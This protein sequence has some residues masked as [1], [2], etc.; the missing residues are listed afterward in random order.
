MGYSIIT[1]DKNSGVASARNI[2]LRAAQG[3]Y[4]CF[5]DADDI[6]AP[7]ALSIALEAALQCGS[8]IVG[9][10]WNLCFGKN[11]RHMVQKD[12]NSSGE[13]L[14]N[15]FCGVM[16]WNLWLYLFRRRLIVDNHLSFLEGENMGEDMQFVLKAF[17][18]SSKVTQIHQMLYNYNAVNSASI[19]KQ[20]SESRRKEINA[21]V[22]EVC[23]FFFDKIENV[24][25][26]E[27]LKLNIKQP[28][29][30]SGKKSDYLLWKEWMPEANSFA[31]K[32]KLLPL[33]TRILQWCAAVGLWPA[34]KLYYL[35]IYRFVYGV[36]FK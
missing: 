12:Y 27:F 8:D 28:L 1:Q 2:G 26:L 14:R 30:V 18:A 3:D 36:L 9:W 33:R 35:L 25:W 32:N 15:L 11:S 4:L 6:L 23:G 21:N 19:S 16:R 20:F 22:S 29:L 10:D 5:V 24:E 34:V 13:A 31:L 7:R 17:Q